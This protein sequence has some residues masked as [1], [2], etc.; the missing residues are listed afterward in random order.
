MLLKILRL[1]W[2]LSYDNDI[3]D[4]SFCD[5]IIVINYNEMF[6]NYD[7]HHDCKTSCKKLDRCHHNSLLELHHFVQHRIFMLALL[8]PEP[9]FIAGSSLQYIEWV[10]KNAKKQPLCHHPPKFAAAQFAELKGKATISKK[11]LDLHEILFQFSV[12]DWIFPKNYNNG[13]FSKKSQ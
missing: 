3:H 11:L 9:E 6:L 1:L 7:Q 10:L 12:F 4:I 5:A 2:D 13:N 8:T